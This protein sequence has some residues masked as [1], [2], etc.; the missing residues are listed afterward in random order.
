M[1]YVGVQPQHCQP[2]SQR[3]PAAWLLLLL[4]LLLRL[5]GFLLLYMVQLLRC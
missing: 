5:P 2:T 3:V 1:M 4:P